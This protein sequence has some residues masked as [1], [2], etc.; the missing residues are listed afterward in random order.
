MGLAGACTVLAAEYCLE[1]PAASINLDAAAAASGV[2]AGDQ[3]CLPYSALCSIPAFCCYG[4]KIS[5]AAAI[6]IED[7]VDILHAADQSR[8]C[9]HEGT[10]I[11]LGLLSCARCFQVCHCA[12]TQ[13]FCCVKAYST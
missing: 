1:K 6:R 11:Q 3:H 13:L 10:V 5:V 2:S 8:L 9:I 12:G 7:V 4:W